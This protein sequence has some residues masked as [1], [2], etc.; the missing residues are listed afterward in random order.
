MANENSRNVHNHNTGEDAEVRIRNVQ[1]IRLNLSNKKQKRVQK[2]FPYLVELAAP[3]YHVV[4]NRH[5]EKFE[6]SVSVEKN[7]T[8]LYDSTNKTA[9]VQI[10]KQIDRKTEGLTLHEMR[11][12]S[13]DRDNKVLSKNK[14]TQSYVSLEKAQDRELGERINYSTANLDYQINESLIY[15][16]TP[17]VV[18]LDK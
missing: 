15:R 4:R 3:E 18:S 1:R 14:R 16:K 13:I 11:F 10:E 17:G 2:I 7:R 5:S 9:T 12:E 8:T 6:A